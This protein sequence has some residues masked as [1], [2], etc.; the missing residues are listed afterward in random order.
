MVGEKG[1]IY[2]PPTMEKLLSS[3]GLQGQLADLVVQPI[4]KSYVIKHS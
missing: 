3:P 4:E 2:L 1:M